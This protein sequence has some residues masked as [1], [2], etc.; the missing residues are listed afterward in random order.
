VYTAAGAACGVAGE[1]GSQICDACAPDVDFKDIAESIE[2]N[3]LEQ[4]EW[5]EKLDKNNKEIVKNQ[6]KM[7]ELQQ[8]GIG[9][10]DDVIKQNE[11]MKNTMDLTRF[12]VLYAEDVKH[13]SNVF[14]KF[15]FLN[16]GPSGIIEHDQRAETFRDAALDPVDGLESLIKNIFMMLIGGQGPAADAFPSIYED[17]KEDGY[18]SMEYH[19]YFLRTLMEAFMMMTTAM[20]MRGDPLSSLAQYNDAFNERVVKATTVFVQ[21]CGCPPGFIRSNRGELSTLLDELPQSTVKL[22]ENRRKVMKIDDK[23]MRLKMNRIFEVKNFEPNQIAMSRL[24]MHTVEDIEL[25]VGIMK[26]QN[27]TET[28]IHDYAVVCVDEELNKEKTYVAFT[29]DSILTTL[30]TSCAPPPT[31]S[32]GQF[33]CLND[34][35]CYAVCDQGYYIPENTATADRFIMCVGRTWT[36]LPTTYQCKPAFAKCFG[37]NMDCCT[38]SSPCPENHGDCDNDSHCAG[39]LVCGQNNCKWMG[40]NS[41][42]DCCVEPGSK[43]IVEVQFSTENHAGSSGDHYL[44]IKQGGSSCKTAMISDGPSAGDL[45][46][47]RNCKR[48]D[49]NLCV[50]FQFENTSRDSSQVWRVTFEQDGRKLR[51]TYKTKDGQGWWRKGDTRWNTA[52]PV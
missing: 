11:E 14:D 24:K 37:R 8:I 34:S 35:F 28:Q 5:F 13:L 9:K 47:T 4:M 29:P 31:L 22:E 51:L 26:D 32:N 1:V 21:N 43:G 25:V 39:S 3:H 36:P 10:M 16:R 33:L 45:E 12:L 19:E 23:A 6:E 40:A 42:A 52:C 46:I 18:C 2:S 7:I 48:L 27:K 44:H 38:P 15:K 20:A 50:H 41:A 30:S 49:M 17:L